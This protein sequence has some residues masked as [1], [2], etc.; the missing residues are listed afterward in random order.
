MRYTVSI[1]ENRVFRRLYARGRSKVDRYLAVY[2]KKNRQSENRLGLTVSAKLG[3]AVERNRV[4]RRLREAY[5]LRENQLRLGYDIVIVARSRAIHASYHTLDDSLC[6][7]LD[8]LDLL[9][10]VRQ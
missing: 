1:K 9:Q 7:L 6:T 4:R 2:C 8:Q 10:E 3:C 5:R